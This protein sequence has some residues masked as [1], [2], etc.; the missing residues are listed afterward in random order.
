LPAAE[1]YAERAGRVTGLLLGR[2]GRTASQLGPLIAEDDAT[3]EALLATALRAVPSPIYIDFADQKGALRSWLEQ[4]GFVS[5][6][7]LTRMLHQRRE[8]FDDTTRT[9]AV[10]GPEFG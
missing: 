3:A 10:A 6:R 1:L 4:G 7:P 2:D 5:Q 8:S 9:Y